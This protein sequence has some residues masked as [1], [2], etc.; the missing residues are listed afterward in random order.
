[1]EPTFADRHLYRQAKD[2]VREALDRA[3]DGCG[4]AD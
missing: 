4:D 2:L 3:Q 1:L